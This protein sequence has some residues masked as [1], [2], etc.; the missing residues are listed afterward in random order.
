MR[1]FF[2]VA[3]KMNVRKKTGAGDLVQLREACAL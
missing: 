3:N 1:F 2:I